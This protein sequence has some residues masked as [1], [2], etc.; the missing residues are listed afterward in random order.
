MPMSQAPAAPHH[1]SDVMAQARH[2]H[3]KRFVLAAILGAVVAG[4]T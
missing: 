3:R 2:R 1:S 4:Y